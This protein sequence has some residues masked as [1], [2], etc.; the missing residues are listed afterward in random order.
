MS[1]LIGMLSKSKG[2][3]LHVAATLYNL[4]HLNEMDS[5]TGE[6]DDGI[7]TAAINVVEICCQQTA[8]IAGQGDI[9]DEIDIIQASECSTNKCMHT[10]SQVTT[11]K[12]WPL[13]VG[14]TGYLLNI[15]TLSQSI[16]APTTNMLREVSNTPQASCSGRIANQYITN[17]LF[18]II[19]SPTVT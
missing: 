6:I 10:T 7:I 1:F 17:Q 9:K 16:H 11:S 8:F 13:T 3:I 4:F 5:L 12:W 18:M 2:Q 15:I 19:L 14:E